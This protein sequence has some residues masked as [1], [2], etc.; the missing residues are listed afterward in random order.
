MTSSY[1]QI[2]AQLR[3]FLEWSCTMFISTTARKRRVKDWFSISLKMLHVCI[4]SW[5]PVHHVTQKSFSLSETVTENV[6]FGGHSL[7]KNHLQAY[8][9][10]LKLASL[11]STH[12]S[13]YS[14][15]VEKNIKNRKQ[16]IKKLVWSQFKIRAVWLRKEMPI[17]TVRNPEKKKVLTRKNWLFVSLEKKVIQC[18][19]KDSAKGWTVCVTKIIQC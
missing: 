14:V 9:G 13:L 18:S 6:F 1:I 3:R 8:S 19:Y 11:S 16:S 7:F 12:I 4:L 5:D 2:H 10:S 17:K 15:L